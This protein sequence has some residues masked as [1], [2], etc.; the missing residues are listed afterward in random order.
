MSRYTENINL[1]TSTAQHAN[2][3]LYANS[4]NRYDGYGDL[5]IVQRFSLNAENVGN[6]IRIFYDSEID[7]GLWQNQYL[8]NYVEINGTI[9]GFF[10]HQPPMGIQEATEFLMRLYTV[11]FRM[12]RGENGRDQYEDARVFL[13]KKFEEL[14]RQMGGS[15]LH[16]DDLSTF[17]SER[18]IYTTD[19]IELKYYVSNTN[20]ESFAQPNVAEMITNDIRH[21][22]INPFVTQDDLERIYDHRYNNDADYARYLEEQTGID[23]DY[24]Q[25]LLNNHP[26]NIITTEPPIEEVSSPESIA[27]IVV[28]SNRRNARIMRDGEPVYNLRNRPRIDYAPFL[29]R[30]NTSRRRTRIARGISNFS[31][32]QYYLNYHHR[33]RQWMN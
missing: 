18:T 29:N 31:H 2:T 26:E 10:Y 21:N 6:L 28:T 8:I 9:H 25:N 32:F 19:F 33:L 24:D 30:T 17:A 5:V 15:T 11:L 14:S 12:I 3:Y 27:P 22:M 7:P 16:P 4:N 13:I 20:Y 23:P 1:I